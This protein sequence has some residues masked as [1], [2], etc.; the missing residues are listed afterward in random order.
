MHRI[1]NCSGCVKINHLLDIEQREIF[2]GSIQTSWLRVGMN[3]F[4]GTILQVLKLV[5][6]CG[7]VKGL[8]GK[9]KHYACY[10]Y[11]HIFLDLIWKFK[12]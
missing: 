9:T 11:L 2:E 12:V 6:E 10:K 5:Y 3:D 8:V 1:I 7:V 4:Y